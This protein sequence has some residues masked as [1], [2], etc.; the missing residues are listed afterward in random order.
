MS[1]EWDL[2]YVL[3]YIVDVIFFNFIGYFEYVWFL[4]CVIFFLDEGV[5]VKG[6]KELGFFFK[7]RIFNIVIVEVVSNLYKYYMFLVFL[8]LYNDKFDWYV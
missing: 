1:W 3:G 6:V 5:F 2:L 7:I 4:I 8:L